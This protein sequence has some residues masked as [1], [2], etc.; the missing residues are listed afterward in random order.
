MSTERQGRDIVFYCDSYSEYVDTEEDD[1]ME[2]LAVFDREGWDK[3]RLGD[4][5]VHTY[6]S[7]QKK[8]R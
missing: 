5:G 2:A 7:Y 6:P 8:R 1:F 3:T 4:E